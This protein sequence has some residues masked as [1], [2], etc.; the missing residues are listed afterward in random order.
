LQ[1]SCL[2]WQDD[3]VRP[4]A[5]LAVEGL[6]LQLDRLRWPLPEGGEP[7]RLSARASLARQAVPPAAAASAPGVQLDGEWDAAGGRL[8]A[9]GQAWPLAWAGAYLAPVLKPRIEGRLGFDA[10]GRWQGAP[11]TQTPVVQLTE[12]LVDDFQAL[13]PGSRLPGVG[14]STGIG[15][16][17][18]MRLNAR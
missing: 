17:G 12:L 11:G 7:A 1:N 14:W 6:Q 4:A 10:T 13:A 18:S 5:Q 3:A 2:Q 16:V 8:Q 15:E 9:R